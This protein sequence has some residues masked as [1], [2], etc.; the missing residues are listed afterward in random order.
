MANRA[1]QIMI[2]EYAFARHAERP[3]SGRFKLPTP[4][5]IG[6]IIFLRTRCVSL[7]EMIKKHPPLKGLS[8]KIAE[9]AFWEETLHVQ[10]E[11]N[12]IQ[13]VMFEMGREELD[14]VDWHKKYANNPYGRRAEKTSKS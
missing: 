13:D 3:K 1:K 2:M 6:A 9:R 4:E 7:T 10:D 12:T 11:R 14:G 8:K 5:Q